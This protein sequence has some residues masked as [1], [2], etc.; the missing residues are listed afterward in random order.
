MPPLPRT[1]PVPPCGPH[2]P[3]SSPAL[4]S[5]LKHHP[6]QED[7]LACPRPHPG[8]VP[9]A[10]GCHC[11]RS[12]HRTAQSTQAKD[13]TVRLTLYSLSLGTRLHR[14]TSQTSLWQAGRRE[15]GTGTVRG[16]GQCGATRDLRGTAP[17]PPGSPGSDVTGR[18]QCCP[19][20]GR[21]PSSLPQFPPDR[22]QPGPCLP[23]LTVAP[24]GLTHNF[25]PRGRQPPD[26]TKAPCSGVLPRSLPRPPPRQQPGPSCREPRASAHPGTLLGAA[27]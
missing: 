16:H 10:S 2:L 17:R 13:V 27:A 15:G 21:A 18:R 12:A 3:T 23:L 19:R 8:C 1:P 4:R 14:A 7:L 26:Q 22:G 11:H 9:P 25:G 24:R 6:L 20:C 5:P